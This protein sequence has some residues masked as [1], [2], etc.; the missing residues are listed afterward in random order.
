M[1]RKSVSGSEDNAL[2]YILEATKNE[3]ESI[4][5][6]ETALNRYNGCLE[7]SR[8]IDTAETAVIELEKRYLPKWPPL[9]EEK[10]MVRILKNQF[11]KE[12]QGVI[13]TSPEEQEFWR[14]NLQKLEGLEGEDLTD[15]KLKL[16]ESRASLLATDLESRQK[17]FETWNT[18]LKE[19]GFSKGF[20]TKE[21]E[22]PQEPT[23]PGWA[24]EPNR[25]AILK[26]YCMGGFF[27][28]VGLIFLLGWV[29]PSMRTVTDLEAFSGVPVVGAIPITSPGDHG[30][31]RLVLLDDN[32][33]QATEAI[34]TLRA[35]LSY[36]G[37]QEERCSFLVT[38]ALA[39]EGKSW[40]AA[41][42]AVAFAQ[43]GDRTLLVDMDLRK[44][45]QSNT[46]NLDSDLPGVTDVMSQQAMLS[47]IVVP[48]P[49]KNLYFLSAGG[50][51]PNPSELMGSRNLPVL[52]ESLAGAFDRVIYD[53]SPMV[54]VSD[55]LPI[56]KLVDS[57][58]LVYRMGKT[59]RRALDRLLKTLQSNGTP[60][61]GIVA[62]GLPRSRR[63]GSYG[64][65]Y[66][67]YGGAGYGGYGDSA[68]PDSGTKSS[69]L[70]QVPS[71]TRRTS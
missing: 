22:V 60:P 71:V 64:Y 41:N 19:A 12:L 48:L 6:I 2:E 35:G 29:D 42:L 16:V 17:L 69:E 44:P 53:T 43:Q 10:E 40:V 7:K 63:K 50:R 61:A 51:T 58:L 66:S 55:A 70:P 52:A 30:E 68:V 65:Y 1:S 54:L 46:L 39:S 5:K 23:L 9:V 13:T 11:E 4:L 28:G 33:S 31:R 14:T 27:I 24:G 59:P 57:V 37:D 32:E 26:K 20:T 18:K 36:L 38:S 15:G 8:Q 56:A 47:D 67:Y 49:T 3:Q 25:N 21:F 62:N 34:R 45:V